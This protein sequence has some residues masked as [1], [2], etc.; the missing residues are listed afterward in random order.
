MSFHLY[1]ATVFVLGE[2][3]EMIVQCGKYSNLFFFLKHGYLF[4]FISFNSK[5]LSQEI[6]WT[7][8]EVIR[9]R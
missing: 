9:I 2:K 4:P 3:R 6:D 5:A 1:I 8:V 7:G